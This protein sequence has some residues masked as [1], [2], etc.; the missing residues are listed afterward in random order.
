MARE[1]TLH[2]VNP[3]E[4]HGVRYYQLYLAYADTP[5]RLQEARVSHDVIYEAPQD[6]DLVLVDA[7]LSIVTQVSKRDA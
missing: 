3:Y 6:G 4:L 2:K 5:D 7:I 1:A